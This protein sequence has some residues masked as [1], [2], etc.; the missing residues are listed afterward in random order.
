MGIYKE[1]SCP[2][3]WFILHRGV[4]W[5]SSH[6]HPFST[7]SST[8]NTLKLTLAS[9]VK[10]PWLASS[11]WA[12]RLPNMWRLDLYITVDLWITQKFRNNWYSRPII[13]QAPWQQCCGC[14]ELDC[15]KVS[16]MNC[17]SCSHESVVRGLLWWQLTTTITQIGFSWNGLK[18]SFF[19]QSSC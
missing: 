16:Y 3:L 8:K 1:S 13:W 2:F 18:A 9:G 14:F 17:D 5:A 7:H 4:P 6:I 15:M 19:M 12:I 11:Q 10:L